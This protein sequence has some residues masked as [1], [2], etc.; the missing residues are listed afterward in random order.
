[1]KKIS[2]DSLRPPVETDISTR[3]TQILQLIAAGLSSPEIAKK[4]FISDHTV[5]SHR[6]NL[7][8]KFK[9]KNSAHLITK[10]F[11]RRIFRIDL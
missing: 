5:I 1:M 8:H 3:E 10:A 4:L 11:Q 7:I 2:F 9:A 6:K